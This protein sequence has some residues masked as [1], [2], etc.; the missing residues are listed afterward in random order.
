VSVNMHARR[1]ECRSRLVGVRAGLVLV[2]PTSV[3]TGRLWGAPCPSWAIAYRHERGMCLRLR[4]YCADLAAAL[5]I[6]AATL[7]GSASMETWLVGS[8]IVIACMRSASSRWRRGDIAR[9]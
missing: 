9:S 5:R 2:L 7:Y 6:T 1:S 4:S 3:M 8:A